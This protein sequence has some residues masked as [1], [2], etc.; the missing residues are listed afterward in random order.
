[1]SGNLSRQPVDA[2]LDAIES[3]DYERARRYLA[4]DGFRYESPISRFSSADDF[5]QHLSLLGGIVR[6]IERR[7]V[8]V[9]GEDVCHLLVYV[10]QLSDKE[11]TKV[12]H[13]SRVVDGRIRC[14][15]VLF[16]THWYR[17]LFEVG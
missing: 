12:A 14:I 15:E 9:D 4:D 2:F 13:W 6:R 17:Q 3:H 10:T 11:A 1:M 16:D 7:K 8:F 5:I